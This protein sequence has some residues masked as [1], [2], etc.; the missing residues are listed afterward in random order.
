MLTYFEPIR[1]YVGATG[2]LLFSFALYQKISLPLLQQPD[3]KTEV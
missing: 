3:I 1:Y 2:I